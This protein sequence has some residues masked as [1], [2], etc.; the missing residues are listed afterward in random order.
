M[1]ERFF[2]QVIS[3]SD[4]KEQAWRNG[5]GTTR[6]LLSRIQAGSNDWNYRISVAA[7][8]VDGPFSF[9]ERTQRHF[10]VLSGHG[11]ALTIDGTSY[12]VTKQASALTFSGE[13]TVECRLIDGP[14][15]DLNF[16]VR[17]NSDPKQ[18]SGMVHLA[19]GVPWDLSGA[20]SSGLFAL[21]AG[22]CQWQ[23]DG[24]FFEL[25][26]GPRQLAWFDSAPQQI[27][28]TAKVSDPTTIGAPLANIAWAMFVC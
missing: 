1:K 2:P 25:P 22:L 5:G 14:T 4:A 19:S 16:M 20:S 10:C 3:L 13:A 23:I 28:F 18:L 21:Q 26:L 17:S 8:N 12:R 9:F 15:S 6:E 7:V 27:T 24:N 11:V